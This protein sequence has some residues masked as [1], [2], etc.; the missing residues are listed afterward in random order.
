[1]AASA[2][3]CHPCHP[4]HHC[5]QNKHP[6]SQYLWMT[7]GTILSLW[8]S[9]S[10]ALGASLVFII[11]RADCFA[12]VVCLLLLEAV[13]GGMGLSITTVRIRFM[14]SFSLATI[15]KNLDAGSWSMWDASS[16]YG[17]DAPR[18]RYCLQPTHFLPNKIH[19]RVIVV[20]R[21]G[22]VEERP[23]PECHVPKDTEVKGEG[24]QT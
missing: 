4:L 1:M 14:A 15:S 8:K 20:D 2:S 24:F 12:V 22:L 3:P 9:C 11:T 16:P 19:K 18:S 6:R 13:D 17:I 5:F 23:V 10:A 21:K 7:D